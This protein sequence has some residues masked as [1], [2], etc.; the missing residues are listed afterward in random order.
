MDLTIRPQHF[1]EPLTGT[2]AN[3]VP[4]SK[5]EVPE[6]DSQDVVILTR[7]LVGQF[8]KTDGVTVVKG[9]SG[10][11]AI[12]IH[13]GK[14]GGLKIDINGQERIFSKK[15]VEKLI[16]DAGKGD[17]LIQADSDVTARLFITGGEGFDT[18]KG[19]SGDDVIVDNYGQ[20]F[21][22]A[23]A[24]N[25]VI[26]ANG[27]DLHNPYNLSIV[28]GHDINGNVISA[29][30]GNDYIEGSSF[31]DLLIGNEGNNVIY[32]LNGD[33]VLLAGH[34][35]NY[36]DGGQ[37]NDYIE[38]Q[39]SQSMLFGGRGNDV[40]ESQ[41]RASIIVDNYG[42][43]TVNA[44]HGAEKSLVN[45]GVPFEIPDNFHIEGDKHFQERVASDLDTLA[46][47]GIG[48]KMLSSIEA[49]GYEVTIKET[50]N[51][52]NS[53][54]SGKDG[55]LKDTVLKTPGPGSSST[56][57]Y[58]RGSLKIAGRPDAWTERPP[59]VG[60][61]HELSHSY[62]AA[63][64]TMDYGCYRYD[65]TV[66]DDHLGLVGAEYQA[67]GLEHPLINSNPEGLNE[68][69]MRELLGIEKRSYY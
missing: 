26:I 35:R 68:N 10:N 61:F 25:D 41:G 65:G 7:R 50:T 22:E 17:D 45:A 34:G 56:V 12:Q 3:A 40:I 38:V 37:G 55:H 1:A 23:G 27:K 46:Q 24:G 8:G 28:Y 51:N 32:G 66:A 58:N 16:I 21:I 67:V 9:T 36:I 19:G 44:P 4:R 29:G 52:G 49:T 15:E 18:I 54:N 20:G 48:Q 47:V 30:D 11:D 60:L 53:C 57:S 43:N 13:N 62:N 39:G 69:G 42:R 5:E 33:D 14:D 59:V 64:G 31:N 63:T 6:Q 2:T